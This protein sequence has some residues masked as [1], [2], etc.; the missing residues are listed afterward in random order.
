M[1]QQTHRLQSTEE[2]PGWERINSRPSPLRTPGNSKLK[3]HQQTRRTEKSDTNK[4]IRDR[5]HSG[6]AHGTKV[7]SLKRPKAITFSEPEEGKREGSSYQ[8]Q[9]QKTTAGPAKITAEL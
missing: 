3:P 4:R 1:A 9:E 2:A 6:K 8:S 5:E 7:G